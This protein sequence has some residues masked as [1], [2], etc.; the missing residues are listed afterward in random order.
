MH[1]KAFDIVIK[2]VHDYIEKDR[3]V[4]EDQIFQNETK[5]LTE[6]RNNLQLT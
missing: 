3:Q 1:P 2:L 5:M 4:L 6:V